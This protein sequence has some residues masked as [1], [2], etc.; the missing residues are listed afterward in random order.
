MTTPN[1]PAPKKKRMTPVNLFFHI[2]LSDDTWR[3]VIGVTLAV[4]L[5]PHLQP[6]DRTGMGIYVMFIAAVVVGWAVSK[7]PSQ[8]IVRKLRLLLPDR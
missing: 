1:E 3:I 7:V 4:I 2:L 5:G 8:W 6:L